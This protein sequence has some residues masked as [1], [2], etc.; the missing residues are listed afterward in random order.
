MVQVSAVIRS[1]SRCPTAA[2]PNKTLHVSPGGACHA[3][4]TVI[5]LASHEARQSPD[6]RKLER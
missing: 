5:I 6:A 1:P 2:P 4:C 3:S